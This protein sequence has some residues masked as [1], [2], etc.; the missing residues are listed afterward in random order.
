M[1]KWIWGRMGGEDIPAIL[2][3]DERLAFV[4]G[5]VKERLGAGS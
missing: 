2:I 5:D 4:F 3:L 1:L